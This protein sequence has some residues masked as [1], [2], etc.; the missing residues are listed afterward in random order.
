MFR[1]LLPP[2]FLW[3]NPSAPH[4]N[5]D[6][7]WLLER[8]LWAPR[9]S[10]QAMV[11]VKS[12]RDIR[13]LFGISR[14]SGLS[15]LSGRQR[16]QIVSAKR[17]KMCFCF[18]CF[19]LRFRGWEWKDL[20]S[21][22][23]KRNREMRSSTKSLWARLDKKTTTTTTKESDSAL[24]YPVPHQSVTLALFERVIQKSCWK[25]CLLCIVDVKKH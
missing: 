11:W 1:L 22:V 4:I 23:N 20:R 15:E 10:E 13:G 7:L 6:L 24:G 19:Q 5:W 18:P 12:G 16:R 3:R 8:H 17:V 9:T 2:P 21:F 25:S 14:L